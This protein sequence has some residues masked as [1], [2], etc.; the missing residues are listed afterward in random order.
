M[1]QDEHTAGEVLPELSEG[2]LMQMAIMLNLIREVRG[3]PEK[4]PGQGGKCDRFCCECSIPR[5]Q[6]R[7]RVHGSDELLKTDRPRDSEVAEHEESF[8]RWNACH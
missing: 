6:R 5:Q 1:C 8:A 4:I 7:F 3:N 2:P